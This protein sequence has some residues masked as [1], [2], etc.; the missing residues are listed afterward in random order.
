MMTKKVEQRICIYIFPE[1]WALML[2]DL[3][4]MIQKAFGNEAMGHT[5]VKEWTSV[6]SDEHSG[7]SLT[8]RNKLMIDT[9]HSAMLD[10]W[11]IIT[12]ELSD[13]L[14]LSPGLV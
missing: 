12:R 7:G 13:K 11:R 6:E 14:G 1:T 4:D 3:Y 5:P 2:R 10:N 9:V 8:S